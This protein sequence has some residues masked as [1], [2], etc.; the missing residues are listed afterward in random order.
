[1]KDAEIDVLR[2]PTV[3]EGAIAEGGSHA[4]ASVGGVAADAVE[5]VEVPLAADSGLWISGRREIK[6]SIG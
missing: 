4:P 6:I 5:R 3:D 1:L 2:L